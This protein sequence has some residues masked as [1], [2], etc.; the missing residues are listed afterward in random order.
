MRLVSDTNSKI[1]GGT[2]NA[3]WASR[4]GAELSRMTGV[5]GLTIP[6]MTEEYCMSIDA[7]VAERNTLRMNREYK[8]ADEIRDRLAAQNIEI[9]DRGGGE[10]V[11]IRRE[12]V[13]GDAGS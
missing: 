5:L 2:L 3:G 8:R 10:T 6:E 4:A 12:P 9:L 11:W 13:C 7:I 1:A